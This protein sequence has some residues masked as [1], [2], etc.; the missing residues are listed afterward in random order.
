M[1]NTRLTKQNLQND[2]NYKILYLAQKWSNSFDNPQFT[3]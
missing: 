2:E 1:K 3:Y